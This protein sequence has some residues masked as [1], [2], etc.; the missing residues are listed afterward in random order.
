MISF[1]V[2]LIV[3]FLAGLI[4]RALMPGDQ[5]MSTG[6]TLLLG[7]I[8]SFLGGFI[9]SAFSGGPIFALHRGGII[10]SIVG[11]FIVLFIWGAIQKRRPRHV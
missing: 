6:A 1:I 11:A 9:T 5:P 7:I 8:G 4:A 3:G 10:M 2:F